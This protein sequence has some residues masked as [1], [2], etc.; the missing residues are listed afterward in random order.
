MARDARDKRERHDSKFRVRRSENLELRTS[1]PASSRPSRQS[2]LA[3]LKDL[4]LLSIAYVPLSFLHVTIVFPQPA[5]AHSIHRSVLLPGQCPGAWG[6]RAET[7][8][9]CHEQDGGCSS[10]QLSAYVPHPASVS[11]SFDLTRVRAS[12]ISRLLPVYS[13][14]GSCGY[15][16][17][18][19]NHSVQSNSD[20][21]LVLDKRRTHQ[22]DAKND[23]PARPQGV[24]RP[25]RTLGVRC[26]ETGD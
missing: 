7:S 4:H 5:S 26:R 25:K 11:A 3:I 20:G 8:R 12:L 22:Q 6:Y 18:Q 17:L 13:L 10:F 1:N 19:K 16:R 24:W 14:L 21:M 15:S 2:R 23:I 9:L